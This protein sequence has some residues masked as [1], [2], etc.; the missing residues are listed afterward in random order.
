MI[1]TLSSPLEFAFIV[2]HM[3]SGAKYAL[4]ASQP[5]RTLKGFRVFPCPRINRQGGKLFECLTHSRH[6]L[7]VFL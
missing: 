3:L 2:A 6:L 1:D 7:C 5:Q 4:H